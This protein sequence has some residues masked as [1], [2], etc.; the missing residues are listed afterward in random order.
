MTKHPTIE[1][2]WDSF[3]REVI[4]RHASLIQVQEMRRAFYAG[5]H[6]MMEINSKLTDFSDDEAVE[7]LEAV[8]NELH[9]FVRDVAAG[10]A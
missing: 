7:I 4:P 10:K 1:E 5:A 8:V 9:Q 3:H 2:A 6:G